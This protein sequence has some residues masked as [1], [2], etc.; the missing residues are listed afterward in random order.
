MRLTSAAASL[1]Q[2]TFPV[3]EADFGILEELGDRVDMHDDL[4][5]ETAHLRST[6]A[7]QARYRVCSQ[8]T[9]YAML[10][11]GFTGTGF[12]TY[13]RP[14]VGFMTYRQRQVAARSIPTR[15]YRDRLRAVSC[16][17]GCIGTITFQV[18]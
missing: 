16:L 4:R 18:A 14:G 17:L 1:A 8:L 7:G 2:T 3:A 9:D 13:R 11:L 6:L 15:E 12:A 5:A 10:L